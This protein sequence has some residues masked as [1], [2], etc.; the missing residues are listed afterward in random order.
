MQN[1]HKN[2]HQRHEDDG[3]GII[4]ILF[5]HP[6]QKTEELEDVEG[7]ERLQDQKLRQR[8]E[9]R[10]DLVVPIHLAPT[11]RVPLGAYRL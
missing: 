1:G 10:E 9:G 11:K 5:G 3:D 7:R 2:A 4:V 8:V 6:H